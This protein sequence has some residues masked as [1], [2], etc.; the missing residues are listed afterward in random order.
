MMNRVDTEKTFLTHDGFSLVYEKLSEKDLEI[1]RHFIET[2]R[3]LQEIHQLFLI[4]KNDIDNLQK[5]DVCANCG[6]SIVK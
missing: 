4:F 6:H 5:D 1:A 3:H 2:I